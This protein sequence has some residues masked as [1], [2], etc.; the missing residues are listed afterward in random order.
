[1]QPQQEMKNQLNNAGSKASSLT[2]SAID[3]AGPM[4]TQIADQYEAA[5]DGAVEYYDTTMDYFAKHPGRCL[6]T[7]A[8]IGLVAGFFL[9]RRNK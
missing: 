4:A 1:M 5:R 2:Q 7:G 6:A 3:A 8:A 9:S